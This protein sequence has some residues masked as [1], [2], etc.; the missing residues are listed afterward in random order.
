MADTPHLI[1]RKQM[2][3]VKRR[4]GIVDRILGA[5]KPRTHDEGTDNEFM[6]LQIRQIVELI[7][8]SAIASDEARYAAK[9]KR[10]GGN[11]D[12]RL[13]SKAGRIL[14]HLQ[15]ISPHFLPQPMGVIKTNLDGSKHIGEGA[16]DKVTLLQLKE[17]HETA[18]GHL[19]ALNPFNE[20]SDQALVDSDSR[21]QIKTNIAYLK[22]VIWDHYKIGLEWI[23]GDE[24]ATLA[25]SESAWLIAFGKP[26]SPDIQMMPASA[27]H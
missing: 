22:S 16:E 1:Y 8:F 10:D 14:E 13:D 4:F 2:L 25:N 24:P 17:I 12:Y 3:D 15:K 18:G 11:N 19:H 27:I 20:Q 5:K 6:W 26:N 23:A 9:R 21:E 7:C